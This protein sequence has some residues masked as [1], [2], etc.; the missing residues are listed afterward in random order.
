MHFLARKLQIYTFFVIFI[1]RTKTKN[2]NPPYNVGHCS[3][4][5]FAFFLFDTGYITSVPISRQKLGGKLPFHL[6]EIKSDLGLAAKW[7][8]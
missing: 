5:Y 7:L 2:T 8:T 3:E 6:R 4:A 1:Q